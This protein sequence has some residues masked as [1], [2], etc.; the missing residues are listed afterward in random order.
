MNNYQNNE[1][2]ENMESNNYNIINEMNGKVGNNKE[3]SE[4]NDI[5]VNQAPRYNKWENHTHMYKIVL[6]GDAGVGKTHIINRYVKGQLPHA[7]IPTIGIE[8]ATKTVTLRD[9]GMIKTQIWDTAGQEKYRS[10]TS[11]HY[12]K[13]VGAFLVY[14]ITKEKSFESVQ[15]W[16][17]E[18]RLHADRDI[19]LMLVGNKLDLANNSPSQRRVTTQEAANFAKEN[20]LLFTESSALYDLNVSSAFE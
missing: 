1:N 5:I 11:A 9:G 20:N 2:D 14:D 17:Q 19:V 8:F 4:K 13:A 7:I 10:I 15:R 16:L 12:R 3:S 18:I 6:V